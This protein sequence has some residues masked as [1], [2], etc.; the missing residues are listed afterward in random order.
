[1]KVAGLFVDQLNAYERIAASDLRPGN[2]SIGEPDGVCSVDGALRGI[3]VVDCWTS[4]A[5]A[6]WAAAFGFRDLESMALLMPLAPVDPRL[7][8]KDYAGDLSRDLLV[9]VA[10]TR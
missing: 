10:E 3:E 9:R 4:A 6:S 8:D 5:R 2:Q 1:M 7:L